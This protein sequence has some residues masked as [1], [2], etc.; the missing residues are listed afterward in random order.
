MTVTAKKVPTWGR[1]LSGVIGVGVAVIGIHWIS[2]GVGSFAQVNVDGW[3]EL[4]FGTFLS[5][6]GCYS[7]VKYAAL[8]RPT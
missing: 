2:V 7:L 8:G 3:I 5:V 4:L 6:V 1:V